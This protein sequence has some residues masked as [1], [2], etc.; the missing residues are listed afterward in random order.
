MGKLSI[1]NVVNAVHVLQALAS[2]VVT[3][4]GI[5]ML[6]KFV[7]DDILGIRGIFAID[8]PKIIFLVC[9]LGK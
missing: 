9:E 6:V 8:G 4:L 3:L 1:F 7:N 5:V 2:I